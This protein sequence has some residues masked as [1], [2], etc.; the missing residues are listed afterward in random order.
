MA[1][2]VIQYCGDCVKHDFQDEKYGYKM[3]VMNPQGKF[4]KADTVKCTV[5]SK[6][7]SIKNRVIPTKQTKK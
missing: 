2:P 7:H 6:I 5:C 3:R 4:D 1:N